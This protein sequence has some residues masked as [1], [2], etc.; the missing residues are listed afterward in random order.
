MKSSKFTF[1]F[2]ID[3]LED[4]NPIDWCLKITKIERKVLE[5]FLN[6]FRV[7]IYYTYT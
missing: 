4:D 5:L 3:L 1:G 6:L 2:K 7:N